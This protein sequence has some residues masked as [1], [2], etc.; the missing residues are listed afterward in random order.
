MGGGTKV[1][2]EVGGSVGGVVEV[3]VPVGLEVNIGVGLEVN[4]GAGLDAAVV[5]VGREVSV[6]WGVKV[7]TLVLEA[8]SVEVNKSVLDGSGGDNLTPPSENARSNPPM[9]ITHEKSATMMP[10]SVPMMILP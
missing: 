2:V 4:V 1:G 8:S 9:T 10:I 5:S 3:N 6:S 7:C